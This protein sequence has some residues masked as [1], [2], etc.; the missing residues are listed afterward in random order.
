MKISIITVSY[1]SSKT[2]KDTF[3]S[4]LNQSYIDIEYIVIDGNSKDTTVEIIKEYE[5]FFKGKD[6]EFKWISEKDKGLYDAMNKGI[7]MATGD[8]IGILNSDDFYCDNFVIEK[9]VNALKLNNTNSLYANLYYVDENNTI[10]IIRNWKSQEFNKKL[11]GNGWHP[12]HPTFFVK[13]EIY[14]KYGIFNLN[15]KIAADYEIMLRFLEKYKI[16]TQ[17][18]D[19]YLVKMRLGGESNQSIKNIIKANNEC[20][21][22]WK[23]N[24][25]KIS[26]LFI[27]KKLFRKILQYR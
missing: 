20:Y 4:V 5:K 15:Y 3:D 18:L 13:K 7:K 8:Y 21:N 25:L 26:K 24:G 10:K 16:S 17:F 22:A 27:I 23:D 14:E 19:E 2:I 11:F 1:N 12:A 6:I 9:V